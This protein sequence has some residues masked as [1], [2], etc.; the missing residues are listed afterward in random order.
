MTDLPG[1]SL[2]KS[3]MPK[4]EG[5]RQGVENIMA[6]AKAD[7]TSKRMKRLPEWQLFCRKEKS[8]TEKRNEGAYR[9]H[10]TLAYILK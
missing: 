7:G 4:Q 6:A 2:N 5:Y 9:K 1:S 8:C 3:L 10:I